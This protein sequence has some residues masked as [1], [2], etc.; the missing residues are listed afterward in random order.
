MPPAYSVAILAEKVTN[1]KG[2][3]LRTSVLDKQLSSDLSRTGWSVAGV[4][5]VESGV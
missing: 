1:R 5:R 2:E 4:S 3:S